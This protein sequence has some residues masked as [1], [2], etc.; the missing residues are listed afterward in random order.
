MKRTIACAAALCGL[1][2]AAAAPLAGQTYQSFREAYESVRQLGGLRLGAIKLVPRFRLTDV[3]YDS[4]VYFRAEGSQVVSDATATVSPELRGVWIGGGSLILSVTEN[5]EYLAFAREKALRAFSNNFSGGL[6]WLALRR[7]SLSAEYHVLSHVRRALSEFAYRIRDTTTGGTAGLFFET[8]RGTAIGF[9]GEVDDFSYR[10]IT[11]G[12]P[13]DVYSRALDRR[14][15]AAA[16]EV[17]YRVFSRSYLFAAAG[18]RDYDFHFE[19]SAWRNASSVEAA[20]GFRFPLTGR[21]RGSVRL[22]WRSFRPDAPD[23][24][25]FSGLIAAGDLSFRMGILGVAWGFNR[26]HSFSAN[27]SAY[28]YVDTRGRLTLSLYLGRSLRVDGGVQLGAIVYPEPQ[29]VWTGGDVIIV[30]HRRDDQANFS[31]GPV[32]RIS[33]PV[34]LGVTYNFYTRT[35]NAPG[36][37]VRRNFV[38]AFVTYEF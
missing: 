20:A 23:R 6:R 4:N 32:L 10:D 35:S 29:A 30:D 22:G 31:V 3:G 24:K 12:T 9:T 21:A 28:Y 13:D 25:G 36:F 37:D 14:E 16:F 17:H 27:E 33:G 11:A 19:E 5:P 7:F 18:W 8:P 34:G 38:G 2:L 1:A 26:D 15:T